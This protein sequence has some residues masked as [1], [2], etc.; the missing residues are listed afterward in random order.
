MTIQD[1]YNKYNTRYNE[2]QEQWDN[3]YDELLNRNPNE[4][5]KNWLIDDMSVLNSQISAYECIV[6]DLKEYLDETSR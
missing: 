2:C 1:I 3:D 5:R 4:K 6:K